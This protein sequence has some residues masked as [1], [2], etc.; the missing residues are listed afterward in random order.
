MTAMAARSSSLRPV[1]AALLLAVAAAAPLALAGAPASA[2]TSAPC[3]AQTLATLTAIDSAVATNIYRGEL[4]SS[5]THI[6]LN[7]VVT[8]PEL[9]S[10]VAADDATATLAAV[11]RIVYHPFW[12]I[13]RLRVYDAAGRLL[14][15]VGGPYVIAPVEGTLES[16]GKAIG[17]FVM[18]VQDDL[19][20]AKLETRSVDDPIGIY[21]DG[22]LVMDRGASFPRRQ[23][24]AATLTL[25]GVTYSPATLT[26]E[27][28]PSGTLQA[29][30]AVP[31]P[32]TAESA[33]SCSAVTLAETVRIVKRLAAR[34]HPLAARYSDFVTT[35]HADTGAVVIVRIGLRV[36]AGSGGPGPS[37]LPAAGAISYEGREWSVY[38]FTP[39][40]PA[41]VYV[42]VAQP[43]S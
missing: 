29:V 27:A 17:S 3:G 1:A 38:S 40:P 30:I 22:A 5:E 33:Q 18:S 28:F 9:I 26:Y 12:H 13:V 41:T 10:A 23:P 19:G 36:I 42:L 43:A 32:S 25:D 4:G 8:T 24:A 31:L 34:F 2:Q 6:D 7:H 14:A 16:N 21:L 37:L 20:F 15:D 11:K 39:T 35:V